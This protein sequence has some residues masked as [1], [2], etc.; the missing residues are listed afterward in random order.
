MHLR[1]AD[2]VSDLQKAG[3]AAA[4]DAGT[5]AGTGLALQGMNAPVRI[6]S[7]GRAL[8]KRGGYGAFLGPPVTSRE[9]MEREIAD[10]A[11]SGT[12]II[13][14]VAS[15]LVS[16]REPGAVTAG[17]F[18]AG[19]LKFIVDQAAGRGLS[20]MAHANGEWAIQD[21]VRAGV[22][23]VE[24]GFFVTEGVLTEMARRKTFWVPTLG[25][26]RR[27]ADA[28]ALSDEMARSI[29]SVI[30]RHLEM[31]RQ[32]YSLGVPL[33]I[34]TDAV[35]PD[36]RYSGWYQDELAW[37]RKAGI[38]AAAVERI[39]TKDGKELLGI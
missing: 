22:R 38:P 2:A 25:A 12:A 24:H 20:V 29:N 36:R 34:G 28:A 11:G 32:A 26:L 31:I 27:A 15:G 23:S 39:A 33:A 35:L 16:L 17:G 21:A 3:I 5:T 14:V 8:V 1:V 6:R 19:E 18:D 37:F 7:A 4:R 10:L 13:K 30:E 9:E